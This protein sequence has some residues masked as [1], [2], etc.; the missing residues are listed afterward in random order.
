MDIGTFWAAAAIPLL[1]LIARIAEASLESVRTIYI[2]KGHANLAAYVGITKTGIWLI[3]TGL[4]LTDLVQYLEPLCLP[5]RLWYRECPRHG[6]R[7]RYLDRVRDRQ[8]DHAL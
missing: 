1:I 8:A 4:V 6:D 2:S 5:R 7:E 3:S